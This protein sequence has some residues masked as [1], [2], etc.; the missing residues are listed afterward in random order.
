[1]K[2]KLRIGI[3]A[4]EASGDTLGAG[5]IRAIKTQYPDCEFVGVCGPQMLAEG[6][7]TIEP[8]ETLSVMGLVEVLNRLPRLFALRDKLLAL[9]VEKKIDIFV[10]IDA[11][12]FN[13]RLG[14][15]LKAQNI[16][17]VH[18]VSP[19]VWAWRQ[20]RV[21]DMK[22]FINTV[23]CLL[24]FEKAF[25]DQHQLNAEFVG[26]PL[27]DE[28]AMQPNIE[29]ARAQLNLDNDAFYVA[30]LPGSRGGEVSRL[31][32][33][34]LRSATLL[35][36]QYPNMTFLIPAINGERQQQ[37]DA[38]LSAYDLNVRVLSSD[39]GAG[40]GRL[41]MAAAN[42]VVL[43]S[44]TATL[45]ALLLKKPMVVVYKLHWLTYVLAKFL[46]KSRWVSLPNLLANKALVPELIQENATPENISAE[47]NRWLNDSAY[48][49]EGI[50]TFYA[51]HDV[52]RRDANTRA[53]DAVL[54]LLHS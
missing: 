32:D 8:M 1:M 28:L 44:G 49:H 39:L 16:P 12:D 36:Q 13:L 41:A 23:L 33:L 4:G 6:G 19:S 47:V 46:V 20:N 37:I 29:Q 3:V 18:Y 34:L 14:K 43:A 42:V 52:L 38:M 26:H 54:K 15:L 27:A 2:T 22:T 30:L 21:H 40:V 25:Y 51:L 48:A 50:Q 35:Q 11:P 53:A 31:G 24:P 17:V 9:F 45:E 7:Q 10:G 5:L